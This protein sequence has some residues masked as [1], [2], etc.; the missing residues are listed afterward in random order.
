MPPPAIRPQFFGGISG[1]IS[2][3][4]SYFGTQV[5]STFDIAA[6]QSNGRADCT[7]AAGEEQHF[8][9]PQPNATAKPGDG[10]IYFPSTLDEWRGAISRLPINFLRQ[11]CCGWRCVSTFPTPDR[12]SRHMGQLQYALSIASSFNT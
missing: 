2:D 3:I 9:G 7:I 8:T 12:R 5:R 11:P 10:H 4:A 1:G 6:K